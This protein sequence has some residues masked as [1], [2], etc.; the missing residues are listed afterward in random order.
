MIE[1]KDIAALTRIF[2]FERKTD[3]ARYC[4]GARIFK[5]DFAAFVI[6]CESGALPWHHRIHYQDYAPQHL[7]PTK[8]EQAALTTSGVG[9]LKGKAAKM[10]SK[11]H[12]LFEERRY[13]VGHIFFTPTLKQWHFF[14]FDQRD[15]STERIIGNS[16]LN[17]SYKPLMA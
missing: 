14:Y 2:Y 8:E 11:I 10:V 16:V 17:T 6:A 4:K 13:L 12:Q 7:Q 3:L 15:L 9:P 1:I 5:S